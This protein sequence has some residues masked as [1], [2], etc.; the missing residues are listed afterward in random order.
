MNKKDKKST[1]NMVK[2]FRIAV[3]GSTYVG[4]TQIINRF[5][6]ND[7]MSYYEP[8]EDRM[9]YRKAYNLKED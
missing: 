3:L 8:T 7:F 6:N 1:K 4:K 5:V 9:I 2:K